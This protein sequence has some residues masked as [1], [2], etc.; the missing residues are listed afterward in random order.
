MS[1]NPSKL[2]VPLLEEANYPTWRPAMEAR[3]RQ[4]GIFRIVTG[5]TQEPSPPGLIPH[6]QDAQ[7]HDE[8]LPQ[9]ALILNGQMTLEYQKQ[10][11]A[12]REREEKAAGNILAHLS[13]LQQ[14]HVKNKG[15]DA[16][17]IWDALKLVHVQQVPGICFSAYNK[18]FSVTKGANETLPAVASCVEDA[19]ARVKELRPAVV[20]LATGTRD[21]GIDDLNNELALMAM[22]RALPRKEYGDFTLLLICQKDLTRGNV[23]A[24]FQV[25]QT[26]RDTHCGP[27]LSPSGDTALRAN[28]AGPPRQNKPSVKCGF[29]TGDGHD[30]DACFKKDRAHKDAQKAIEEHRTNRD[31]GKKGRTNRAATPSSSSPSPPD[32]AKGTE[33]A[34]SASV[35]LAGSPDTHA[36]A[37]WIAD[38]GAT[39]HMS[40]RRS[41]FTKLEPLAI[42]IRVANDHVVYS[43]GVGSVVLE[44]ADKS[45]RP[46]LLSRVLYVP[47]LQ[48]NLLSVLHLVANHRFRIEIEGKEMVFLQSSERRFTAAICN[49]MAWL[50]ASTPPAPEAALHGEAVMSRAL[51]HRRLC[52]IGADRLEQA[53]KG[54]V[55]TGLV[56]ESDA[57]AP[58]H[59]EPCI[60]GKHHRNLFPQR[61]SMAHILSKK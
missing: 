55:A 13:C 27:L 54:K 59:C 39:S 51:W 25:E 24:A 8:P 28:A 46:V 30:E 41:W 38:T 34:A 20:R 53:I 15:S 57:P 60:R 6:M 11:S 50:N 10:L 5:E 17:G 49:N 26:K 36:D 58:T 14:T 18:L 9:A 3:L 43:E 22:L 48:N 33:L 7:G 19:L 32:S 47:A 4:L 40:P 42:P 31:G 35:R 12:Y 1:D 52:H 44:P 56:I 37:H 2:S 29:C 61:A 23:E 45:L 16:K 21:Y